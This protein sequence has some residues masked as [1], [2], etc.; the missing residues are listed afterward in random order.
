[1]N[2]MVFDNVPLV[3]RTK[4]L[5]IFGQELG[6]L[7]LEDYKVIGHFALAQMQSKFVSFKKPKRFLSSSQQYHGSR[8]GTPSVS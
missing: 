4:L 7:E 3:A 6:Q 8:V 2:L 5:Q 1:M